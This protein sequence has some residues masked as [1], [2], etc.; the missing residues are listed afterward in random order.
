LTRF[1]NTVLITVF[2]F[3]VFLGVF[4]QF[5]GGGTGAG[6][7]GDPT[8]VDLTPTWQNASGEDLL[9]AVKV[10]NPAGQ[11]GRVSSIS[12]QA[13]VDGDLVDEAVARVPAGPPTVVPAKGDAVVHVPVDL[14][15]SFILDWWPQYMEDGEDAELTIQGTVSLR[16]DDG[17]HDA[18]FEWRSKWTG[19]LAERLTAAVRNC[20]ETPD[21]LCMAKS[22]FFWEDGALHATL[23]LHNPGPEAV[24]VRNA[25]VRL[26]FGDETVVSGDVDLVRNLTPES[27]TEV[28]LALSFSQRAIAEWWPDHIARCERTPVVLGMD[29]Q[30]HT[31]PSDPDD[32]GTVTTLQWTFPSSP[33]QTRFVCDP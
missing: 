3:F 27:D 5:E 26:F 4:W 24:A 21:D 7:R 14:P 1:I 30:A 18:T 12:Y 28:D 32:P 19:E 33:F 29:L 23:S 20:D 2:A 9:L 31:L 17:V 15:D 22:D 10:H 13:K 6:A 8:V 25:T 16:R 11:E